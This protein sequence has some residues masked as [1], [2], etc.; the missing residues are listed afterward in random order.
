MTTKAE[1]ASNG[2]IRRRGLLKW[3]T[4]VGASTGTAAFSSVAGSAE[5]A[6]VAD[7]GTNYIPTSEK[8]A[9]SGVATLDGKSKLPSDQIPDLSSTYAPKVGRGTLATR[10]A[11][12]A[13]GTEWIQSDADGGNLSGA[14]SYF[15]GQTWSAATEVQ[16][17]GVGCQSNN[18]FSTMPDPNPPVNAVTFSTPSAG[19]NG[20]SVALFRLTKDLTVASLALR[21]GTGSA[22]YSQAI[23][24]LDGDQLTRIATTGELANPNQDNNVRRDPLL[25]VA[26]LKA[27]TTYYYA[28][29]SGVGTFQY[30][31]RAATS[32]HTALM[33]GSVFGEALALYQTGSFHPAPASIDTSRGTWVPWQSSP[34]QFGLAYT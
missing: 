25:S 27:G 21:K 16:I 4:I 8:G 30:Y 33:I 23:Y 24:R 28:L 9:A 13:A 20:I 12:P 34:L 15:D 11:A 26:S 6:P 32:I 19:A 31:Q 7:I 22:S 10:P 3:G 14:R 2:E 17:A 5:A 1:R 18:W 29:T